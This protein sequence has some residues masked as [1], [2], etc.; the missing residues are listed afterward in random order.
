VNSLPSVASTEKAKRAPR[1]HESASIVSSPS[2]RSKP[3]AFSCPG[4]HAA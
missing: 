1:S 4:S 2:A 3:D